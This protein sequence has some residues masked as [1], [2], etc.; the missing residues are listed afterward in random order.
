MITSVLFLSRSMENIM[1]FKAAVLRVWTE[2]PSCKG[3]IHF[4]KSV[5]NNT[6]FETLYGNV[7][8]SEKLSPTWENMKHG[9][10][11][12]RIR[13]SVR[14]PQEIV[15][16]PLGDVVLISNWKLSYTSEWYLLIPGMLRYKIT[17]HRWMP[18]DVNCRVLV[19]DMKISAQA[20]YEK[21]EIKGWFRMFNLSVVL[22]HW[23]SLEGNISHSLQ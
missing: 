15:H 17:P 13:I 1:Q 12:I 19:M 10:N 8:Q 16:N 4:Y 3:L 14:D 7:L 22:K 9:F 6:L 2:N 21:W 18:K 23:G 20:L 11:F 5:G